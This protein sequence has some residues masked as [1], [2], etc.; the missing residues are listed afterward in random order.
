[1]NIFRVLLLSFVLSLGSLPLCVADQ[2]QGFVESVDASNNSVQIK[3]P[4]S[5]AQRSVRVH[6]KVVSEVKNGSV[7]KATFKPG[8][9][10]AD[11]F[12]VLSAR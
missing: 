2:I 10:T 7:V 1:M 12:E 6:P 11:T 8:A 5:G 4:V 9:D 3:D